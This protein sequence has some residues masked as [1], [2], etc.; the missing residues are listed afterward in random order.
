MT[1]ERTID[2]TIEET[3]IKTLN[4]SPINTIYQTIRETRK[5]TI[6]RTYVE[7]IFTHQI[8]NWRE[9]SVILS[10]LYPIIIPMIS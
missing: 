1:Y 9:I 3:L 8:A 7:R 6:P 5:E 10:F 4:E 2:Q